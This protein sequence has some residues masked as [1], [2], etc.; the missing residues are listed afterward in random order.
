MPSPPQAD[1]HL[2]DSREL[3]LRVGRVPLARLA[4]RAEY[5]DCGGALSGRA[6]R[7]REEVETIASCAAATS[8]GE[9]ERDRGG[10]A[11]EL[12]PHRGARGP[13]E[14][15]DHRD[16]FQGDSKA[17]EALVVEQSRVVRGG[18]GGLGGCVFGREIQSRAPFER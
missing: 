3:V 16:E 15:G 9:V 2:N 7:D 8:L 4:E 10:G 1:E 17:V 13:S 14:G 6:L 5:V 11:F 12:I 18:S